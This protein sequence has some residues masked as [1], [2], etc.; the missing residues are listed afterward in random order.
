MAYV[1]YNVGL[2][3]QNANNN[4]FSTNDSFDVIN[5]FGGVDT[6]S[7]A[8]VTTSGVNVDLSIRG[9]QN[10]GGSYFDYLIDIENLTGS[11]FNDTLSGNSGNNVL[12]GGAGIDTVSYRRA[13]GAVF[14]DLSNLASQNTGA[15]G[16]DTLKNFENLT[17]SDFN[18]TLKGNT[19]KNILNG[20]AGIDTVAYEYSATGVVVSLS[21]SAAQNTIGAGID[22]LISFENLTGSFFNDNLTGS[23][24]DNNLSGLKG[25]DTLVGTI[26][27]DTLDGGTE[28]D[29]ADYRNLG[30]SITLKDFGV[31]DKDP[32]GDDRLISIEAVWGSVD[33]GDTIDYGGIN[34]AGSSTDLSSS[35][36][37]TPSGLIF[38][39]SF[40]ENV[41]GSD[42]SDSITGDQANNIL[43]GGGGSDKINGFSGNDALSG[44]K[45]I[46]YLNGGL[47]DDFIDGGYD[48]D[49][50]SDNTGV[51]IFNFSELSH[52]AVG[53]PDVITGFVSGSTVGVSD[54][55]GLSMIDANS[56]SIGDEGFTS[57]INS[58]LTYTANAQLRWW[59]VGPDLF[60]YGN[61]D[62]I[63]TTDEFAIQISGLSTISLANII[64]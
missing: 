51:D 62:G 49:F 33:S 36:T 4:L 60:L 31:V 9:F 37:N 27:Y 55:I 23:T 61:T 19:G 21:I 42:L 30:G 12:N 7:Y 15:A 8:T 39:V 54:F 46:D 57:L 24:G 25:L 3:I 2:F 16:W 20:G 17:G 32:F 47:G 45:G 13:T 50:L 35:V 58:P 53:S 41:I 28:D 18:D 38:T 63:N 22:T 5:G 52:T 44:D 6:V 11:K 26:G 59:T 56:A 14:V 43:S 10:T 1:N 34:T 29:L 40:F 48:Q 64:P